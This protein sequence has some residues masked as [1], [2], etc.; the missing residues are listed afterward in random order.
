[1]LIRRS[2]M[3]NQKNFRIKTVMMIFIR[4]KMMTRMIRTKNLRRKTNRM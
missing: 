2:K 4:I 1:M 3:M